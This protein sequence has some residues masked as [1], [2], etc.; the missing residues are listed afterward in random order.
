MID[1][2]G[3]VK[4]SDILPSLIE[5]LGRLAN[6]SDASIFNRFEA[7]ELLL[8]VAIGPRRR[9]ADDNDVAA[10]RHA[11]T[12]LSE[13]N[14]FLSQTMTSKDHRARVRLQAAS[15]ATLVTKVST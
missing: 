11:C 4:K 1:K 8:R 5:Y 12:A 10:S 9:H 14:L 13:A 15:L 7:I 2:P 3:I 6:D